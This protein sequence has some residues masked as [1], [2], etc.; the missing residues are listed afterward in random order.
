M[1]RNEQIC[2]NTGVGN[3][4][5]NNP[6]PGPAPS[7][8][9]WHLTS[10]N[11]EFLFEFVPSIAALKVTFRSFCSEAATSCFWHHLQTFAPLINRKEG[12]FFSSSNIKIDVC[13]TNAPKSE[14]NGGVAR[15]IISGMR[16][17][18]WNVQHHQCTKRGRGEGGVT[19]SHQA[20]EP[21]AHR[22]ML[23]NQYMYHW[24]RGANTTKQW[25]IQDSNYV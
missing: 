19:V 9:K 11:P 12:T 17:E 21:P 23:Y 16:R 7:K 4:E 22:K 15:C 20:R 3:L 2:I 13:S 14:D 10:D 18:S 25:W 6:F 1:N 24:S 5:R 8:T